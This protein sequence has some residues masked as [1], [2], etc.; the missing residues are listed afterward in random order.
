MT[1]EMHSIFELISFPLFLRETRLSH[2]KSDINTL[3]L[4]TS[5]KAANETALSKL[6]ISHKRIVVP[7]YLDLYTIQFGLKKMLYVLHGI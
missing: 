3:P 6:I 2:G 7:G 5:T 1:L 4:S